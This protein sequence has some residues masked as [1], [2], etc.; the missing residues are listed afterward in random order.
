MQERRENENKNRTN[1]KTGKP[2]SPGT[3]ILLKQTL[4]DL[5]E[6]Q[7]KKRC[8]VDFDTIDLDFYDS[9]KTFMEQDHKFSANNVGKHIKK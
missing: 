1:A 7:T 5:K 9:F 3:G 6:Y 4:R 2:L 8:K